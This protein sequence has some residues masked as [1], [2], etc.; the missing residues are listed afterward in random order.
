MANEKGGEAEVIKDVEIE[1]E[2]RGMQAE[3]RRHGGRDVGYAPLLKN[4]ESATDKG[5][6]KMD[7]NCKIG[8]HV[9][10]LLTAGGSR[11]QS[12]R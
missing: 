5:H 9:N 8:F 10:K 4:S 7:G 6:V 1:E 2:K 3:G 12:N 11:L